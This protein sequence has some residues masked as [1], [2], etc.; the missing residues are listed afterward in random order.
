MEHWGGAAPSGEKAGVYIQD[1]TGIEA[2]DTC[3]NY[4]NQTDWTQSGF[5]SWEVFIRLTLLG[6]S[7]ACVADM[8]HSSYRGASDVVRPEIYKYILGQW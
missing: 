3:C 4:H 1:P 5:D 6:E 8:E 7:A 2:T